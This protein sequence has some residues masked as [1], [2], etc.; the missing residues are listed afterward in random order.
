[1]N[2]NLGKKKLTFIIYIYIHIYYKLINVIIFETLNFTIV[3]Y[4]RL[5]E[6]LC[7]F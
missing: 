2:S 5:S 3:N 1:M 4:V 6:D 7:P